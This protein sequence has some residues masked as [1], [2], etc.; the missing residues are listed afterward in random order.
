MAGQF[1]HGFGQEF[2]IKIVAAGG[3]VAVLLGP[4]EVPGAPDLEV[5][6]RELEPRAELG[7]LLQ[8]SQAPL[9]LLVDP[10]VGRNQQIGVGLLALASNAAP[11]LIELSEAETVRAVDDDRV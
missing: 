2:R 6:H 8:G 3:D 9:C 10:A 5:P 11:Q 1:S 4:Q 7:K